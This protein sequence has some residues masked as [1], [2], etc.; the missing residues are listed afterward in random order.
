MEVS[1][2]TPKSIIIRDLTVKLAS[3]SEHL[4]RGEVYQWK[5]FN[6]G[7]TEAKLTDDAHVM[8]YAVAHIN[9]CFIM[10]TAPPHYSK[11]YGCFVQQAKAKVAVKNKKHFDE[12]EGAC[13]V[14]NY[15]FE[16]VYNN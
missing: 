3:A 6:I 7:D 9:E 11:M 13:V 1:P 10:A 2:V 15:E 14:C 5:R 12:L 8:F 16:S 4:K